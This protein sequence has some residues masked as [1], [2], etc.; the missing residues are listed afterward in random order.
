M[1][2]DQIGVQNVRLNAMFFL[3]TVI[4][5]TSVIQTEGEK[6][7]LIW[8]TLAV[9]QSLRQLFTSGSQPKAAQPTSVSRA[10]DLL[11]NGWAYQTA[12][13]GCISYNV[14]AKK[15]MHLDNACRRPDCEHD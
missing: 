4:K 2:V 8:T 10:G 1:T 15:L 13:Y 9:A 3:H 7:N 5:N 12:K 6:K 14:R 11:S